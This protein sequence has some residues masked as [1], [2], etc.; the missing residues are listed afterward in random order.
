MIPSNGLMWQPTRDL[1]PQ[2]TNERILFQQDSPLTPARDILGPR[3][4]HPAES[5]GPRVRA[6]DAG[7]IYAAPQYE[8]PARTESANPRKPKG[9]DDPALR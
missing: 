6:R 3:T 9:P 7:A 8:R 1:H 2:R 4:C 5:G